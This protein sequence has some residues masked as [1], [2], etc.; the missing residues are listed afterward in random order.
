[1][2]KYNYIHGIYLVGEALLIFAGF[3]TVLGKA[4][5]LGTRIFGEAF[6]VLGRKTIR[7]VMKMSHLAA[8]L[9]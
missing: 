7:E 3:S 6:H 9:A 2:T 4:F 1:M 5:H 8:R